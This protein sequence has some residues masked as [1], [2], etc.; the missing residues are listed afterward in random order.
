VLGGGYRCASNHVFGLGLHANKLHGIGFLGARNQPVG[1]P[2][3]VDQVHHTA[4]FVHGRVLKVLLSLAGLQ[5]LHVQWLNFQGGDFTPA[6]DQAIVQD[7]K[8][9]FHGCVGLLVVRKVA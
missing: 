8:V 6:R 4:N 5:P 2:V 9:A 3:L 7:L 1:L